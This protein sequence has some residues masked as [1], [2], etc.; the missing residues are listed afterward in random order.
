MSA[1]AARPRV[2]VVIPTYNRPD[3]LERAID[4]VL[5]QTLRDFEVVVLD[6]ASETDTAAVMARY[7]DP[8]ITFVRREHNIGHRANMTAT[9]TAGT[10][11]YITMLQDKEEALP[12]NL[13]RKVAML[14]A[15][16]DVV[17]V[18]GGFE[19][20]DMERRA[21]APHRRGAP[22]PADY[23]IDSTAFLRKQIRGYGG[24]QHIS[25]VV[26]RREAVAEESFRDEDAP[27]DD[28]ALWLR[29]GTKGRVGYCAETLTVL[30]A[31][32]G[33]STSNAYAEI[34][35]G[36]FYPTMYAVRG[37]R[38]V[39]RSFLAHADL[40]PL[41]RQV[42]R[43]DTRTWVNRTLISVLRRRVPRL[44]PWSEARP[45]IAEAVQL[46]PSLLT[47]PR[48]ALLARSYTR[49]EQAGRADPAVGAAVGLSRSVS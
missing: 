23:L 34:V 8:R 48:I 49:I 16:P 3:L 37:G 41:V 28:V 30:R 26:A 7:D 44:R 45:L 22:P 46:S 4:S 19:I 14:D 17:M 25:S 12:R 1:R 33:W 31:A 24:I 42:L 35:N 38:D 27:A 5:A 10:A 36:R 29:V 2:T 11:P 15:H 6:N 21:L 20:Q 9:F 13:E 47:T 18:H 39:R 43:R 32:A 40:P